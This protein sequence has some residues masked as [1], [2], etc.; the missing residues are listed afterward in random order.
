MTSPS[1]PASGCGENLFKS[2]QKNSWSEA[3]QAW[4]DEVKDWRYGVG[5]V[6][7]GVVGHFT[8]VRPQQVFPGHTGSRGL[9]LPLLSAGC[10]VPLQPSG[11]CFGPLSQF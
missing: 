5:S 7:G 3:V 6:N 8:Q 4:Y 11:L 9:M 10:L 2:S 1:D